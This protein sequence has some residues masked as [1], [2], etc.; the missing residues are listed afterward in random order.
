MSQF[1]G[2]DYFNVIKKQEWFAM[3]KNLEVNI[4]G[5]QNRGGL[6]TPTRIASG[7]R[8][9]LRPA[10]Y[11][12]YYLKAIKKTITNTVGVDSLFLPS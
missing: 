6:R 3:T 11:N 2:I 5:Q 10:S 7:Y 8:A 1:C 9:E 4:N 12:I